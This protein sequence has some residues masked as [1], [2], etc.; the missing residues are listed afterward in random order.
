MIRQPSYGMTIGWRNL[1]AFVRVIVR[2][3]EVKGCRTEL[4]S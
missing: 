4:A 2:A 3:F 1:L